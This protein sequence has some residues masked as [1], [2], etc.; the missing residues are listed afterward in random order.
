AYADR[1]EPVSRP[2]R[3]YRRKPEAR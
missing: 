1:F 3:L 2:D